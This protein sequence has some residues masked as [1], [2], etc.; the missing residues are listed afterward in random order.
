MC[1]FSVTK[2]TGVGAVGLF[3]T[4]R[5]DYYRISSVATVDMCTCDETESRY[6]IQQISSNSNGLKKNYMFIIYIYILT[7]A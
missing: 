6:I 4:N 7:K 2:V 3:C 5:S 1:S